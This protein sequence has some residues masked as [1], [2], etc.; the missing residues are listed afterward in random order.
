[1]PSEATPGDE[2]RDAP[3]SLRGQNFIVGNGAP[4]PN[5]G[6]FALTLEANTGSGIFQPAASTFQGADLTC[7]LM[8]VPQVCENG[9]EC[10]FKGDHA[11]VIDSKG[12]VVC[13]S[14]RQAELYVTA[15][16]LK[17]PAPFRRQ[18]P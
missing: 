17:P 18:V 12:E 15:M 3:G 8:S 14:K 2:I 4:V 9:N 6:Q 1:M 5:Q 13:R 16:R 10:V 7:P 11:L